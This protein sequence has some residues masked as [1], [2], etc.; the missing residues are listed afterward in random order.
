MQDL[1]T[2]DVAVVTGGSNGNG[3]AIALAFADQGA[4]VVVADVQEEPYPREGD[5]PTHEV[6][7]DRTDAEA[8]YVQCDVSRPADL[9]AAIDAADALGGVTTMVNNAG[10]LVDEAVFDLDEGAFDHLFDVHVKGTYYGSTLATERMVE[11]GRSGSVINMSSVA[12]LLGAGSSIGYCAAKGAIRVMTYALADALGPHG[13]RANVIH[14][15]VIETHLTVGDASVA[16]EETD[17]YANVLEVTPL[18]RTG[19]PRDVANAALYLASDLASFVTG[20]SL[21]VD[22]GMASSHKL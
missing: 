17:R 18:G 15:G 6:I 12:G 19:H 2:D 11:A 8:V 4:D 5:R 10:V 1:L 9:E 21:V 13:I 22:G 16:P 7:A 20:A 14:P 3:R